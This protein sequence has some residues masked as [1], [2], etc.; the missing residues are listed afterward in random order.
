MN[1]PAPSSG[2]RPVDSNAAGD[3]TGPATINQGAGPGLRSRDGTRIGGGGSHVIRGAPT[4]TRPRRPQ[5]TAPAR[6]ETRHGNRSTEL[7]LLRHR[8]PCS[9]HCVMI[10]AG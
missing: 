5:T 8:K 7:S 10:T 3:G 4:P 1:E 9:C 6:V 2:L